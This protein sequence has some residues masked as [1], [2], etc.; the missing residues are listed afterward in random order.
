MLEQFTWLRD[1]ILCSF[2]LDMPP[3]RPQNAVLQI[4]TQEESIGNCRHNGILFFAKSI[5]LQIVHFKNSQ[6]MGEKIVI[7]PQ[8][9]EQK[10][11]L[12]MEVVRPIFG[13]L[14]TSCYC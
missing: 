14:L 5:R 4:L 2:F 3:M 8:Q 6:F 1:W 13:T 11:R 12:Y 9:L 7:V 10:L